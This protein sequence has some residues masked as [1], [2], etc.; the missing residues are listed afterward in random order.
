MKRAP[1]RAP[2]SYPLD[3]AL[4]LLQRVWQ[5]SHAFERLSLRMEAEL[6]VTA[7]QRLV[8][9]CVGKYPGITAGQLAS[10]LQVDPGT[11][12]ATLKRLVARGLL[13]RRAD[14]KDKRRVLLGLTAEGRALNAP[15][16]GTLEHAVER[17]LEETSAADI[18]RTKAVL[19]QLSR[20][21]EDERRGD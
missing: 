7:Q 20:L 9:R 12:S 15:T 21:V 5:L 16:E 19:E 1:E 11:V 6:G 8:I 13:L 3:P 14:P 18:A 17:L 10:I 2:T 4:D